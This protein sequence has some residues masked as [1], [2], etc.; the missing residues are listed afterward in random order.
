MNGCLPTVFDLLLVRLG[1]IFLAVAL[2]AAIFG[3]L[4]CAGLRPRTEAGCSD[5]LR[6]LTSFG[7][8]VAISCWM[9]QGKALS[10]LQSAASQI[11]FML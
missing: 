3:G 2:A 8:G 10:P 4:G 7:L 11:G 9:D 1:R 6:Y 5:D